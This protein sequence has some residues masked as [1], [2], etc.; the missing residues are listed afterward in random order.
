[1]KN[2]KKIIGIVCLLHTLSVYAQNPISFPGVYNANPEARV[3]SDGR[4][5]RG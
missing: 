3:F 1:M 4:I 2:L 5:Q